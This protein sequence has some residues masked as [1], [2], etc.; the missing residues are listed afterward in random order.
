MEILDTS[1]FIAAERGQV[2]AARRIARLLAADDLVVSVVTVFELTSGPTTPP[3]L[4]ASYERL[5]AQRPWV[6]PVTFRIARTAARLAR[7]AGRGTPSADALIAGTAVDWGLTLLTADADF[8]RY[9]GVQVELMPPA[10][11][12]REAL[13]PYGA[14]PRPPSAGA[15]IRALRRASGRSASA[16][17][18]AAGMAR[19]NWARLESG[20]HDPGVRTLGRAAAA[21]GVPLAAIL[22]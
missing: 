5:F 8:L 10:P 19:S 4:L 11:V 18:A 12:A 14:P 1:V 6:V 13:A 16:L 21:L 3:E 15:R 2:E 22:G 17:A 7:R 20:R 9:P